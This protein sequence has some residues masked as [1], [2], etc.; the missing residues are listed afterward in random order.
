MT[1]ETNDNT[2]DA[3][4]VA[5]RFD[6]VNILTYVLGTYTTM[7]D[8]VARLHVAAHPHTLVKLDQNGVMGDV[9]AN[10]ERISLMWVKTLPLGDAEDRTIMINQP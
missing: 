4:Y 5:V 3:V 1:I 6:Q 7:E 2:L 8:A 9:Y 10:K